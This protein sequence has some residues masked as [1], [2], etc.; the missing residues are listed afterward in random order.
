VIVPQEAEVSRREFALS[1]VNLA[2]C[3]RRYHVAS[4]EFYRQS[5]AGQTDDRLDDTESAALTQTTDNQI[6]VVTYN[7]SA[8][9][10]AAPTRFF[11]RGVAFRARVFGRSALSGRLP[12]TALVCD[13][14]TNNRSAWLTE[15]EVGK[16]AAIPRARKTT[17]VPA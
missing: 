12:V 16:T 17:F 6:D 3:E 2:E 5:Q 14:R 7:V 9:P 13:R 8:Q 15:A 10:R 1:Q 4:A 11:G